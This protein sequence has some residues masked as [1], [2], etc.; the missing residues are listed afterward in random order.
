MTKKP[1][2]HVGRPAIGDTAMTEALTVRF[3]S[4]LMR[5]IEAEQARDITGPDKGM[6]VRQ[7][8]AEAL[9]ARAKRR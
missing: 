8:V 4:P 2:K 5:E 3:P 7:L 6:M 9:A 1:A